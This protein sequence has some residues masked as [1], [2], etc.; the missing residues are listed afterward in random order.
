MPPIDRRPP[1]RSDRWGGEPR[2]TFQDS[3]PGG[4]F[5]FA[6][7]ADA[8]DLYIAGLAERFGSLLAQGD[9]DGLAAERRTALAWAAPHSSRWASAGDHD[10]ASEIIDRVI[11]AR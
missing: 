9:I 10:D 3:R 1:D 11:A 4:Q 8:A 7:A 5:G 2:L 6:I